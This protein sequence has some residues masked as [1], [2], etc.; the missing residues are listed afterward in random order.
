MLLGGLW[1]GANWTFVV[2][3]GIHGAGLAFERL[4][5]GQREN[6]SAHTFVGRWIRRIITFNL[7]CLAW[8]FFRIPSI[9]GAWG[10]LISAGNWQWLP[11]YGVALQFLAVYALMLFLVDL[12]LESSKG[13]YIFATRP[14]GGRV[15]AGM[16]LAVLISLLGANLESAFI[17]FRF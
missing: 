4:L 14:L 12:Q 17:Y 10:Q 3:G 1:H 11:V 6:G 9:R 7:V 13:E 2:W 15:T 8:V 5:A 16:A